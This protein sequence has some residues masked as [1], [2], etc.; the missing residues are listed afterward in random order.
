MLTRYF[1]FMSNLLLTRVGKLEARSGSQ[2][3]IGIRASDTPAD[4]QKRSDL[5]MPRA[6]VAR[7]RH[8]REHAR[9]RIQPPRGRP[10]LQHTA[11]TVGTHVACPVWQE[12]SSLAPRNESPWFSKTESVL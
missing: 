8:E 5:F 4:A 11:A 7:D 10:R 3:S 9:E 12:T 2:A 1:A 6:Q